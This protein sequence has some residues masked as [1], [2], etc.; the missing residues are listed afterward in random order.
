MNRV[1]YYIASF[2]SSTELVQLFKSK[3]IQIT[4]ALYKLIGKQDSIGT[5]TFQEF[6]VEIDKV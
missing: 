3:K 4:P 6:A 2:S 1:R 5:V